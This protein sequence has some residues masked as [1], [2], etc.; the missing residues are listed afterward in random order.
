MISKSV[1]HDSHQESAAHESS[2]ENESHNPMH[3]KPSLRDSVETKVGLSDGG[4]NR[5]SASM[6]TT[7]KQTPPAQPKKPIT[8]AGDG[9]QID[10]ESE[11]IRG[12]S[13]LERVERADLI[14]QAAKN[15]SEYDVVHN[16]MI[17]RDDSHGSHQENESH[18]PMHQKK[19]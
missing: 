5:R 11:E 6:S 14:N 19:P 18:N 9:G 10:S 4:L 2:H 3:V 13:T 8:A 17:K 15:G 7:Q 12:P 1:A 16:P